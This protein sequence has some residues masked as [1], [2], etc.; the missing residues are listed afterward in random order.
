MDVRQMMLS[1]PEGGRAILAIREPVTP[2]TIE[3]LEEASTL[4]FRAFRRDALKQQAEVAGAREYDSWLGQ[5]AGAREYDS[6]LTRDAGTLEYA[7]W[8]AHA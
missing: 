3:K 6:W 1:I 7:S 8:L 2:E 4:M 5:D